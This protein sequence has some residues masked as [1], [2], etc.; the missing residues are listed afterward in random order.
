MLIGAR[1][2]QGLGGAIMAPASLSIITSSF[3][4][5]PERM[6]AVG[7]WG[8]M[9]GAGGATG[10]LLG[11]IITQELNWRWILLINLPIGILA[12]LVARVAVDERRRE[13]PAAS[14]DLAGALTVTLGLL[15]LVYGI[16][17]AGCARLGLS[18]GARSDRARGSAARRCSCSSR[19][20]LPPHR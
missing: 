2:A 9:N 6:R 13:G 20:S 3:A 1:A 14:F 8:A 7:L 12:A 16:V 4:A 10:V 17:S 18:R 5:G 15:A 11:G 19:Q